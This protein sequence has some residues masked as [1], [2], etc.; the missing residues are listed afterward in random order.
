METVTKKWIM[1]EFNGKKHALPED[2]AIEDL[3][4]HLGLPRGMTINI[5]P[6]KGGF[7]I[8]Q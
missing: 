4:V 5:R 7:V 8:R 2:L 1:V 6:V 3:L